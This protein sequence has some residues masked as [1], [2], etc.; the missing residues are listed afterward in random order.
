MQLDIIIP[1]FNN[2]SS[3]EAVLYE[4]ND[5]CEDLKS[6]DPS[7]TLEIIIVN[8][9]SNSSPELLLKAHHDFQF[10]L[11]IIELSRN[12]G[13][14]AAMYA[15]LE[16]SDADASIVMSADGQDPATLITDFV[17]LWL[18][19]AEAVIGIRERR[20]DS[21][22]AKISSGIAHKVIQSA[23]PGFP[24]TWFDFHLQSR[25]VREIVCGMKGRHRFTQGDLLHA[26][27]RVQEVEYVRRAR[28]SG[29]SAY[30]ARMRVKNF[31]DSILD[32]PLP[33][34]AISSLI[35][36]CLLAVLIYGA[37]LLGAY[38][39]GATFPAGWVLIVGLIL[40]SLSINAVI[41]WLC[42]QYLWRI[43]DSSRA[44]PLYVVAGS[45]SVSS[46]S[47]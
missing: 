29:K 24:G 42:I 34:R 22:A 45:T 11:Q 13:Q 17:R 19:G 44:K 30:S 40:L 32:T 33:I 27:F 35:K 14:L 18:N 6:L 5:Q 36:F 31:T 9:G 46:S 10:S 4:I 20:K 15:G 43:Y 39:A 47:D 26:G 12:F 21:I 2:E 23:V 8:D 41:G 1:F 25:R 37:S 16:A 3:I 28:F 7:L 38:T